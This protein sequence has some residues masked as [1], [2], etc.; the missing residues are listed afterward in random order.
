MNIIYTYAIIKYSV[1]EM[2]YLFKIFNFHKIISS[3]YYIRYTQT[4]TM[5]NMY[6]VYD[7]KLRKYILN[8]CMYSFLKINYIN[9]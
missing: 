8:I 6:T 1:K 5:L 9:I 2:F 3:C 4:Y 7:Y